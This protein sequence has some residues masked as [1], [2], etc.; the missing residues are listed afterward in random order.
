MINRC[1][2]H[3]GAVFTGINLTIF[4]FSPQYLKISYT[5][6]ELGRVVLAA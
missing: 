1:Y 3:H 2:R 4:I 5:K 6:T